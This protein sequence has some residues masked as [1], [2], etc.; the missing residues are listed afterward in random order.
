MFAKLPGA[1]PAQNTG[2]ES[3]SFTGD[4]TPFLR[5][6]GLQSLESVRVG[7]ADLPRTGEFRFPKTGQKG[8]FVD[9]VLPLYELTR[10]EAGTPF[11]LRS[12]TSNDGIWQKDF[13]VY[14][15]GEWDA[16]DAASLPYPMVLRGE[17]IAAGETGTVGV[18]SE[19]KPREGI[20]GLIA[21]KAK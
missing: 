13:T 8:F 6:P 15:T 7:T 19:K 2:G 4:G 16:E 1:S 18:A 3:R 9:S 11:L 17:E 10:D 12:E 5:V 20:P 14:V 21:D